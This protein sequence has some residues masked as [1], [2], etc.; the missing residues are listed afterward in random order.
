MCGQHNA[1]AS[2]EDNI[3]ENTG[4]E[5]TPNHRTEIKIPDPAGNRTRAARLEGRGSTT[6]TVNLFPQ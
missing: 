4:K 6:A 1:R 5:N 3:G 2:V